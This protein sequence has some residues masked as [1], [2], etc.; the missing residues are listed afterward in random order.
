MDDLK[1]FTEI[2]KQ[3]SDGKKKYTKDELDKM[4]T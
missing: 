2:V 1:G 4:W 3:Q